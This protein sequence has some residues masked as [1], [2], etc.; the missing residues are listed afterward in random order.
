[1]LRVPRLLVVRGRECMNDAPETTA[2]WSLPSQCEPT[3]AAW[4]QE[5][6]EAEHANIGAALT[7]A[8]R[9]DVY[10]V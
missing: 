5:M 4:R 7:A 8:Y 6:H 10:T 1:M 9:S 3:P 2:L